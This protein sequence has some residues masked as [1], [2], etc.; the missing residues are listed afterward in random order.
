MGQAG[1]LEDRRGDI[2]DVAELIARLAASRDPVRPAHDRAVT[3]AAP[4]RGDLLGPLVGRVARVRPADRVVVVGLRRAELV[5]HGHHELRRLQRGHRVE[6]GHLVE[7]AVERA[8]GRGTVVAD[9]HVDQRVVEHAELIDRVDQPPDVV[10]GVLHE[11]GIDLH[12]PGEHRLHLLGHL[13]PGRDLRVARGQHGVGRDHTEFLLARERRLAQLVPALV[14]LAL[15]L[16]DPFGRYVVRRVRGAGSEVHEERLV[17]HQRLLLAH[18][19]DR[20]IGEVLGQVVALLRPPRRLD[21]R[22]PLVQRGIPLVV[23]A[24]DEAIEV[25][26]ARA[27][28][29]HPER[30]HRAGLPDRHLV[31]L[32]ELPRRVPV[33]LQHLR[34]RRLRVRTQ[35]TLARRRGRRLGDAA[36][37]DRVVI[38]PRQQRRPR[39][40]AQRRRVKAR[41]AQALAG[42]PIERRRSARATKRARRT[43]P[44]IVDQHDQHVRRPIR[45]PQRRDR[46]KRRRGILGVIR[47]QAD[48]SHVRNRQDLALGL[49]RVGHRASSAQSFPRASLPSDDAPVIPQRG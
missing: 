31:A 47:H 7:G 1:D 45:R 5:Q 15:V 44:H 11:G 40:S 14:E 35:R 17:G 32:A 23:L 39:R 33:E 34:E 24:A 28:G 41:I 4:V 27:G 9:D 20:L 30:P 26:K 16:V 8:L 6:V 19:R 2:D 3:G 13:V 29:P 18:P 38:A 43:E 36:H 46:R 12:L 25:L 42:E 10:V 48:R 22:R 49:C 37:P 21:R